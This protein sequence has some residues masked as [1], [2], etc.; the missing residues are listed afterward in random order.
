[1]TLTW[2]VLWTV[3]RRVTVT[4]IPLETSQNRE[5]PPSSYR[6]PQIRPV[7]KKVSSMSRSTYS[8]DSPTQHGSPESFCASDFMADRLK[9]G[10]PSFTTTASHS[11]VD[12]SKNQNEAV[13]TYPFP[14][15]GGDQ[16]HAFP[17]LNQDMDPQMYL[18]PAELMGLFD[19]VDM[20]HLFAGAHN[21]AALE[22]QPQHCSGGGMGHFDN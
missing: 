13:R 3:R 19:G 7:R 14:S 15:G 6:P 2:N 16:Q 17:L 22:Q 11:Q 21:L 5:T 4:Q 10:P 18:S 12:S 20:Q 1:M 9:N 8:S